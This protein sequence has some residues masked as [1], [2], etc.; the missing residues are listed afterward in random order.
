MPEPLRVAIVGNGVAGVMVASRLRALAPS[1]AALEITL[2]A[3][4]PHQYYFRVRLPEVFASAATAEDLAVY[5]PAWYADRSI[6]VLT[7]EEVARVDPA[8]R[9]LFTASGR[10]AAWDELVLCTGADCFKPPIPG[11]DK[12]GVITVREYADADAVRA[13]LDGRTRQAVVVGGGLLG[14]EAAHHLR[15]ARLESV[16][17]V[18]V[19]PRLLP[20][21]LD[22]PGAAMLRRAV[23]SAGCAVVPGA[24]VAEILGD[25]E[26]RGQRL[27]DGRE[28]PAQ[29]VLVSAGIAPRVGLARAMGCEVRRGIVVDEHMR[30]SVPHVWAAGDAAEFQGV[31][32]GI[33]PAAMEQAPVAAAGILGDAAAVYRQ[34]VPQNT[35]K[36]AG[37]NL[38]SIGKAILE[39]AEEAL[40]RVVAK[41]DDE[42]LRYEK[43]VL[44]DGTL[45]GCILL[46]SRENYGF[47]T[48]RIGKPVTEEEI[49]ALPW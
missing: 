38:T 24:Q 39:P 10:E 3:R 20:R 27:A 18:E 7:G 44:R 25:E 6:R 28:L 31:V 23:E 4:E 11:I 5:K 8:A 32:W 37:V 48:G 41:A 16:T 1:P 49:A 33:I 19:A 2:Y 40:H 42:R 15:A 30:T 12:R 17:I 13:R 29:T 9:R 45:V 35:L 36:V 46:G 26:V 47:A 43:Y 34:T 14:L 22:A 21:Q